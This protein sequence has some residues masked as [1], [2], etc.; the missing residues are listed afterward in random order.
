VL[1]LGLLYLAG[2]LI[3][4]GGR[5]SL[6]SALVYVAFLLCY[7]LAVSLLRTQAW[8]NRLM[9]AMCVSCVTVACLGVLQYLLARPEVQYLDL[10]L[11]SDLDGRVYATLENPNM[12]AEYLVLLLP[13]LLAFLFRQKRML[14]CN[15]R[16]IR[17]EVASIT[18]RDLCIIL[19]SQVEVTEK[20]LADRCVAAIM[21]GDRSL[22]KRTF[23]KSRKNFLHDLCTF[24]LLMLESTVVL[25]A[26]IMALKFQCDKIRMTRPVEFTG[27]NFL[28][29]SHDN[30]S[31]AAASHRIFYIIKLSEQG[32]HTAASHMYR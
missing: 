5:A 19:N 2:G 12:L 10:S 29:F 14:R 6:Q 30:S 31:Q 16:N 1:L 28:F 24:F 7:F 3:T 22:Y 27:K 17:A 32:L 18:D 25:A 20:V 8:I 11:F 15:D 26:Q 4:G 21:N 13:L 9:G 23:A